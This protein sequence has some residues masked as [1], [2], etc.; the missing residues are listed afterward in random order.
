[1][2]A[3]GRPG[4]GSP[5]EYAD[6]AFRQLFE[7]RTVFLHGPF[8]G[9]RADDCAARLIAL[10]AAGPEPITLL[11]D[12]AGG[13]SDAMFTL[14]DTMQMLRSPVHTRCI[15]Q[16][17]AEAAFLLATGTGTRSATPNARILLRQPTGSYEGSA[18]D[19]RSLADVLM[20][21]RDRFVEVLAER[22]GKPARVVRQDTDRGL[23]LSCTQALEYGVIDQVATGPEPV[24]TQNG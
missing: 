20:A 15:G 11:V 22:T 1:M 6:V 9:R 17:V 7:R 13:T 19:I 12:A 3:D 24:A 16:A 8:D 18:H 4:S 14:P 5:G 21:E 23:W 2:R 10:D